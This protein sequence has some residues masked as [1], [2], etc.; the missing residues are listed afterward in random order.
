VLHPLRHRILEALREPASAA[1]VARRLAL[2]RQKVNYHLRVLERQAL[3]EPV[4]ERRVG[5]CVERIVRATARS[6]LVRPDILGALGTDPAT[7]RDRFSAAYL[8]AAAGAAI[9]EVAGLQ[10]RAVKAGRG[11]ATLTLQADVRFATSAARKAF[12]EALA[13]ALARLAANYHDDEAPG[14][15][16]FRFLIAGHPAAEGPATGPPR[17]AAGRR[18]HA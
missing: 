1:G 9:R 5:N 6:Y 15:R 7:V 14:G 3:V 4:E 10:E 16:R 11:L 12:A 18:T 13:T 8:V 17:S 2:P